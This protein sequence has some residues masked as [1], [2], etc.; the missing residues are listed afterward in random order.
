MQ[1]AREP[2]V[3]ERFT[4]AGLDPASL[5]LPPSHPR[6]AEIGAEAQAAEAHVA[7]EHAA[8]TLAGACCSGG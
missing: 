3:E 5:S 8:Q 1:R 2:S 7:E 6:A 4:R